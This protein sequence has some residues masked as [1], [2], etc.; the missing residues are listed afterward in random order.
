MRS[1]KE[2][3][4]MADHAFDDQLARFSDDVF[5]ERNSDLDMVDDALA[6]T[7]RRIKSL[8]HVPTPQSFRM[9]QIKESVMHLNAIAAGPFDVPSPFSFN[10]SHPNSRPASSLPVLAPRVLLAVAL[11][12]TLLALLGAG[13]VRYQSARHA[14]LIPA[15]QNTSTPGAWPNYR[16]DAGRTGAMPGPGIIGTPALLWRFDTGGTITDAAALSDGT[17]YIPSDGPLGLVALDASTGVERWHVVGIGGRPAVAG[18]ML[19][20]RSEHGEERGLDLVA[21]DAATGKEQWRVAGTQTV[22]WTP[23]ID[24]GVIYIPVADTS[25]Q[26]IDLATGE[27]R[28][29]VDLGSAVSRS[30]ALSDDLV[31]LGCEDGTLRALDRATGEQRWSTEIG[32]GTLGVPA[33]RDG[34]VIISLIDAAQPQ[35]ISI[36]LA[37]GNVT[38]RYAPA[39]TAGLQAAAV[40]DDFVFLPSQDGTVS[41]VHTDNGSL[42]WRFQT[43]S[44]LSAA[45][46]V[47]E[48]IV[49]EPG[50]DGN[51][52]A[53]D[54]ATGGEVW[55]FPIDAP[56][57]VESLVVG[58]VAFV[59]DEGGS[60]YAV[61][62]DTEPSIA[63]PVNI[64]A[65]TPDAFAPATFLRE[66]N[67]D[68]E[69]LH[70]PGDIAIDPS[71]RLLW[72]AD[73]GNSRFLIYDADGVLVDVW[74]EQGAEP[75]KFDFLD[76][77][78]DG[79]GGI[80]F[81]PDGSFYVAD[82]GNFRIQHF[83][84]ERRLLETWGTRG[85]EDGQFLK[86]QTIDVGPDGSV[87]AIDDDRNDVQQFDAHGTFIRKW[88]TTGSG[89][90]QFG[91]Q[92]ALLSVDPAGHV[93]VSDNSRGMVHQFEADGTWIG[94]LGGT[95]SV[96]GAFDTPA[97]VVVDASGRI[98]VSDMHRIQVFDADGTFLTAWGKVGSGPGDLD[99]GGGLVLDGYGTIFV[100]DY[101]NNRVQQF[102]LPPQLRAG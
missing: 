50:S 18:G 15:T 101:Y 38:W 72:I 17:I 12:F 90:G 55:R 92:L 9:K 36:D 77:R 76:Y 3:G 81:G 41:A 39:S 20:T 48:G 64:A 80:A 91:E 21:L 27:A 57:S 43:N 96:D 69:P 26:A 25:M 45:P 82:S 4:V 23:A 51:F 11:V 29:S 62:G 58:G 8:D 95:E 61:R 98:Y 14:A 79:W 86:L 75:G 10:G 74:G 53:I 65:G 30:V 47:I 97:D 28:W 1:P 40:S 35:L 42:G 44:A 32:E 70:K 7:I 5:A 102:E 52:Y 46:V 37:T 84:S 59:S 13:A 94:D 6:Q 88:G 54:A 68:S 100:V 16:G 2:E 67:G 78:N 56:S 19:V 83:D 71:T 31:I 60:V 89:P 33:V 34:A 66:F 49:Y 85:T 73:G 93:W 24:D 63:A 22:F 87:Y 99:G